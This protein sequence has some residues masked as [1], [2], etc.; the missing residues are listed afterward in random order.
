MASAGALVKAEQGAVGIE[1]EVRAP[2]WIGVDRAELLLDGQLALHVDSS[3][4]EHEISANPRAKLRFVGGLPVSR[5]SF[6][7]VVV[8]GTSTLDRVLP[9]TR[10][11]PVAFTNPVFIDADGDGRFTPQ[12]AA[13]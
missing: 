6:L 2:P 13:R 5:D 3:S 12:P 8:R 7:V 1:L 11:V 9:G 4:P 10:V